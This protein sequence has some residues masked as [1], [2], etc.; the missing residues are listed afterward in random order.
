MGD[1]N[2]SR[3]TFNSVPLVDSKYALHKIL[4]GNN[5]AK[6]VFVNAK[7][8]VYKSLVPCKWDKSF[9]HCKCWH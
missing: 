1:R 6:T 5:K 9:I 8:L 2:T 7:V 4:K 3:E